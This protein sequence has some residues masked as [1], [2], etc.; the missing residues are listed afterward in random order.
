MRRAARDLVFRAITLLALIFIAT[1]AATQPTGFDHAFIEKTFADP[2]AFFT[3]V[4]SISTIGLW[5]VTWR[6][7][8]RQGKD[9]KYSL[10]IGAKAAAAAKASA[11]AAILNAS[12]AVRAELPI[13]SISL[14]ALFDSDKLHS[15]V[16]VGYPPKE[17]VLKVNF[18][19]RGR[20]PAELIEICL[21]WHISDKLANL[22]D[23]R[24]ISPYAPGT[25]IDASGTLPNGPEKITVLLQ[26]DEVADL[27]HGTVFLWVYGYVKFRDSIVSE[28]HV[29]PFCAKWQS[30]WVDRDGSRH[31][32]G[33]VYDS[34]TPTEY[35]KKT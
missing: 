20:S 31:S 15:P 26:D 1:I 2:V 13:V 7:S 3:L 12:A 19:N 30:F 16:I 25:F 8:F 24:N 29:S 14:L 27:P 35:T 11:E 21:E 23:Y 18:K 28:L 10:D 6:S 22:P 4:L 9:T 33:F 5:L 17:S 32:I 34:Q